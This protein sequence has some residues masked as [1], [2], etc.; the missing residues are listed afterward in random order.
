MGPW[1]VV[2]PFY[3]K[4]LVGWVKDWPVDPPILIC[5]SCVRFDV[6]G[7]Y[8]HKFVSSIVRLF[9]LLWKFG[10][11]RIYLRILGSNAG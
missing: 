4:F 10:Y 2:G 8:I 3:S 6:S 11:V 1:A 7:L 5:Y 9:G